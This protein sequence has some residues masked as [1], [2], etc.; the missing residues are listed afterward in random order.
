[1]RKIGFN[2]ALVRLK[3][4]IQIYYL[5]IKKSHSGDITIFDRLIGRGF[6]HASIDPGSRAR[7]PK[8]TDCLLTV[9]ADDP[10]N[11]AVGYDSVFDTVL[12]AI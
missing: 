3:T 10:A 12:R 2:L 1:M 9:L 6:W 7:P 5:I 11:E 8:S 4:C